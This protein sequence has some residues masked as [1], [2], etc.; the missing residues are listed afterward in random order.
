MQEGAAVAYMKLWETCNSKVHS[1]CATDR[2]QMYKHDEVD[3]LRKWAADKEQRT[4]KQETNASLGTN[5]MSSLT[6]ASLEELSTN[7]A[8]SEKRLHALQT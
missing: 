8:S 1:Y 7:C 4:A 2:Y 3:Y 5:T 6:L